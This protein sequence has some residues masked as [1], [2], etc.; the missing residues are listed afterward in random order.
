[1]SSICKTC[2]KSFTNDSGRKQSPYCHTCRVEFFEQ[3]KGTCVDCNKD[4][5][6]ISNDG[7]TRRRRCYDCN[8]EFFNTHKGV[9]SS[10]DTI[11]LAVKDNGEIREFCKSCQIREH[12]KR[13]DNCRDC[14]K[15]FKAHFDNGRSYEICGECHNASFKA[16]END[17]CTNRAKK[18]YSFCIQ[19]FQEKKK[20][21]PEK[22]EKKSRDYDDRV[23]RICQTIRCEMK[24]YYMFCAKCNKSK[25]ELTEEFVFSSCQHEDCDYRGRGEFEFCDEHRIY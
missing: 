5:I 1:M 12:D 11:F 20:E 6:A 13:M 22:R 10:C 8:K 17:G 16:C 24:T 2:D 25:K 9:C 18:P 23:L 7:N 21:L 14:G 19:C 15:K 4:F 3:N